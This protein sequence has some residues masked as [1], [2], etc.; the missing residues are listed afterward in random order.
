MKLTKHLYLTGFRGTGKSSV[1]RLL[2]RQLAVTAIDLDEL[3]EQQ[4]GI[5][6]SR[7]FEEQGE[8]AFRDLESMALATVAKFSPTLISLGGGA[9]L[10]AENRTCIATTGTCIWLDAD[11]NTIAARLHQDE[12][13]AERRPALTALPGL[14]EIERLLDERRPIYEQTSRHRIET[15]DRSIDQVVDEILA[16]LP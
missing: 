3:V 4:A 11:A 15:T 5:S 10:R 6:I 7:I 2:A 1:A 13:T 8:S 12:T 9:I 16:L 14:Q